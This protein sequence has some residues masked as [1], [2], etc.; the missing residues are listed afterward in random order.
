VKTIISSNME[1]NSAF[2]AVILIFFTSHAKAKRDCDQHPDKYDAGN[3]Y[4]NRHN[5]DNNIQYILILL[6]MFVV[7]TCTGA[8]K[9]Q[10]P[11]PSIIFSNF[12]VNDNNKNNHAVCINLLLFVK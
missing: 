7:L 3:A 5:I 8:Q 9:M 4:Q 2:Y 12:C 6:I 10:K 11:D 1:F